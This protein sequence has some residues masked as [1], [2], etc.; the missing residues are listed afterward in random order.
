MEAS[1]TNAVEQTLRADFVVTAASGG[2][3]TA[4]GVSPLAA[5][6]I[7]QTPGVQTVSEIRGGQWGLDGRTMTLLA[8][9]PKTVTQMHES[10]GQAGEATRQL[11]DESVLV[12]D[13]VAARHHWKVGDQV[14]MTFAR[15]G[16]RK[17]RVAGTFSTSTVPTDYVISLGAYQANYAQ[18]LD[19]EIDVRLAPGTSV[20]TG[21]ARIRKALA[22]LPGIDVLDRAHVL[23]AQEKQVK[24]YLVPITGLLALSVVIALLGIANTL[25]L[26]IHERTREL[27]LLRAIGMARR[28]LRT[29]M[30]TEAVIIAGLGAFLGIVVALVFGSALVTALHDH[31]LTRLV[32]PV[33]QLLAWATVAVAAGILAATL[34]ARRAARLPVLDAVR[35]E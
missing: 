23:A 1:A 8:V 6:R 10:D 3:G 7:R 21:Q 25:A 18:Q 26:S 17:L 33:R 22:D 30:R 2:T 9:D 5:S 13:D 12:R 24:R 16:T 27:G 31:G 35:S 28:Q 11:D 15:T 29:M 34:P 32:V 20:S 14:P 19:L 4:T